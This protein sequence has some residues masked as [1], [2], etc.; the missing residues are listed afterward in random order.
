MFIA[1]AGPAVKLF[2]HFVATNST[3]NT[4][5]YIS[6]NSF[7]FVNITL[8]AKSSMDDPYQTAYSYNCVAGP[9][10]AVKVM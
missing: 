2:H 3:K 6:G 8:A 10:T 4:L 9:S 7:I 1:Q 5:T